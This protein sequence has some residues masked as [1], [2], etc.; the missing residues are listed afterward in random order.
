MEPPEIR[1]WS[2]PVGGIREVLHARFTDHAYPA[3]T[4]DAWTLLIVDT[5]AVRYMLDK[6]EHGTWTSQVT[7]LPPHVPHDGRATSPDGFRKRVLYLDSDLLAPAAI[8]AAVD[9]PGLPDALLRRRIDQ[10]HRAL[11]PFTEHLEAQSRLALIRERLKDRL[12]RR[13]AP[14]ARRDPGVA[15]RLRELLDERTVEGVAL[16]E[17]ATTLQAHPAH[18]VRAF[19][20]AYGI[21]PHRYLTGRRVDLARRLLLA[22]RSPAEVAPEVGFY[23]QAHLGRHF[24]R[25][26]GVGP[27]N[28]AGRRGGR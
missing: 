24:K 10:L 17:A 15:A 27:A 22:G 5:G 25:M 20:K 7:L 23:D 6:H 8:G 13:A 11:T 16:D 21:P 12:T 9:A 4:H 18:L 2:P 14:V 19:T 26:L 28:Y 3:H 1:A